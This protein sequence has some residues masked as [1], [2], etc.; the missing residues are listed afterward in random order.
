MQTERRCLAT[1][2][3]GPPPWTASASS[4]P[5]MHSPSSMVACMC[6]AL[7]PETKGGRRERESE[8]VATVAERE[9]IPLAALSSDGRHRQ[10]I[11]GFSRVSPSRV[12]RGPPWQ[13][14]RAMW[15]P[16]RPPREV[17]RPAMLPSPS[18][19]VAPPAPLG[20]VEEEKLFAHFY[21]WQRGA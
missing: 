11:P 7:L 13:I 1:W 20:G 16:W 18:A 21:F 5:T 9:T 4:Q 17:H 6:S 2:R 12:S 15:R 14:W 8:G 10:L 19:Q 3:P